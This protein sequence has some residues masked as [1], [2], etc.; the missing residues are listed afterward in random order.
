LRLLPEAPTATVYPPPL[1]KKGIQPYSIR[2]TQPQFGNAPARPLTAAAPD[3]GEAG[4]FDPYSAQNAVGTELDRS[5][6]VR[7]IGSGQTTP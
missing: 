1:V 4:G 6:R 5:P 3:A 7:G 2:G